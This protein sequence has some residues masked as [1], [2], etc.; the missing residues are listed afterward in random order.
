MTDD[1]PSFV[2]PPDPDDTASGLIHFHT[3]DSDFEL[4]ASDRIRAWIVN[5]IQAENC[6]L[7]ELNFIFCSDSYLYHINVAYL[8]HD[9]LTDIITF[10]Y[11]EPPLIQGDIFI[12]ID[13]ITD[14]AA[15]LGL[16]FSDE[17]H[18]VIIH[19]VLHLCGYGDK[20][21][22]E[23]KLMTEKEDAALALLNS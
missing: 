16:P 12:S 21:A 11:T 23:K 1:F 3:Q 7:K 22:R 10:P 6:Q 8:Q 18:R 4:A 2:S 13:R 14:N 5:V 9:T 19:G 20:T 17:L 15:D